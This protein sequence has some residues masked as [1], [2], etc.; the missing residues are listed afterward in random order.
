M[1]IK[2]PP[3][4]KIG[5]L[6]TLALLTVAL[7]VS[8]ASAPYG[9]RG[10]IDLNNAYTPPQIFVSDVRITSQDSVVKG[11]FDVYSED[12]GALGDLHYRIKLLSPDVPNSENEPTFYDWFLSTEGFVLAPGEKKTMPFVYPLPHVPS[13]DYRLRIL[14]T[15]GLGRDYGWFDQKLAIQ[16]ANN[17]FANVIPG[18]I[19]APEYPDQNLEPQSGPNLNPREQFTIGMTV[20]KNTARTVARPVLEIFDFNAGP[21]LLTTVSGDTFQLNTGTAAQ[22]DLTVTT[23]QKPGVY[24]GLLSLKDIKTGERISNLNEYRWVVRG[25]G[26]NILSVRLLALGTKTKQAVTAK[27][28]F[29]GA[30]DAETLLSAKINLRLLD[31]SGLQNETVISENLTDAIAGGE[32]TWHLKRDLSGSPQIQVEVKDDGGKTLANYNV[33]FPF[34]PEQTKILSSTVNKTWIVSIIGI[35]LVIW[36]ILLWLNR[37]K[38]YRSK[39]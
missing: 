3:T 16:T 23:E 17:I 24:Y 36:G 39:R 12:K 13:G 37:R 11:A 5:T 31:A 21:K 15:N 19:R 4:G 30:A 6:I 34:S 20:E 10:E 35:I 32:A 33:V 9:N 38:R 25:S 26:A 2:N 7:P 22:K 1:P 27:I 28:E 18:A 8:A 14:I 29:A